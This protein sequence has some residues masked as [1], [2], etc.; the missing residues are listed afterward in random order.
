MVALAEKMS[1][2]IHALRSGGRSLWGR[3]T[4]SSRQGIIWG[5]REA[6]KPLIRI[7]KDGNERI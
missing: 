7:L 2:N 1:L 4:G 3:C 6:R 5:G